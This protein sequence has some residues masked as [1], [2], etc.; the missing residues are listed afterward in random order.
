MIEA[1][2]SGR[3]HLR[4]PASSP[5]GSRS[6]TTRSISFGIGEADAEEESRLVVDTFYGIQ[7]D[8]VVNGDEARATAAFSRAVALHRS[9]IDELLGQSV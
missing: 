9:R 3:T 7:F 8:L 1:L 6:V 2:S 5:V 4:A